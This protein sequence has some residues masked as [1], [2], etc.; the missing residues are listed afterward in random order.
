MLKTGKSLLIELAQTKDDA[1]VNKL[2]K[3]TKDEALSVAQI[4]KE[5]EKLN[6]VKTRKEDE[7]VLAIQ[8]RTL[9]LI[10][11]SL[12]K[13]R[14]KPLSESERQRLSQAQATIS[15]LLEN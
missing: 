9:R 2:W 15:E 14:D 10:H 11:D 1:L 8:E 12:E 3:K 6:A 13:L 4:R 7:P 5:R